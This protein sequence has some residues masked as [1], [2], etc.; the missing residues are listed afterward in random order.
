[1]YT[2][3]LA[4]TSKK[5]GIQM[6]QVEEED[7]KQKSE[8]QRGPESKLRGPWPARLELKLENK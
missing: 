5:Q 1:M 7:Q 2:G 3:L 8:G 4:P 6:L